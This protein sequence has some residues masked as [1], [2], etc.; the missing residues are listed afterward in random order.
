MNYILSIDCG[1]SKIKST[2]Y[3]IYGREIYKSTAGN[4]IISPKRGYQEQDMNELWEKVLITIKDAIKNSNID[5]KLITSIGL[6]GQGEGLWFLDEK[7][8]PVRNAILWNDNRASSIVEEIEKDKYIHQRIKDITGSYIFSGATS[9]ILKWLKK[10]ERE[11]YD[12]ICHI[13]YCKDWLRYNLTKKISV[14]YTDLSTALLNLSNKELA[15]EVFEM[16]D[17]E[18]VLESIGPIRNSFEEYDIIDSEI[19]RELGLKEDVKVSLGMLDVVALALGSG[20]IEEGDISLALGTTNLSEIVTSKKEDFSEFCGYE[21]HI[22]PGKNLEVIG[23]MA[24]TPNLDWVID[25]NFSYEKK[26]CLENNLDIYKYLE[27]SVSHICA[28]QMGIIYHPYISNAGERAPFSDTNARAQFFGLS[29]DVDREH[30]L[31]AVYEGVGFSVRHCLENIEG[32]RRIILTGG[33]SQSSVWPQ[34]ISDITRREVIVLNTHELS[35][36]GAMI[37]AGIQDGTY[38]NVKDGLAFTLNIDKAYFPNNNVVHIYDDAYELYIEI[39][40]CNRLLWDKRS[41]IGRNR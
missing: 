31:R 32:N 11:N 12:K 21:V 5:S 26:Y 29:Q 23:S 30:L 34:I 33:G 27:E 2:V 25:S 6:A 22:I 40:K 37:L 13:I 36:M 4:K 35:N 3:D 1:T 17:I 9:A 10:N 24:G 28:A 8:K 39:I 38:E 15:Y 18:E 7:F 41:K 20:A 19:A 14:E 16:L